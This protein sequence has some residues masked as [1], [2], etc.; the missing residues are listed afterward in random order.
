MRIT[1]RALLAAVFVATFAALAAG[2]GGG[3]G[4]GGDGGGVIDQVITINWGTE[5]PSLDPGLA[6]DTTSSDVL[7]NIMDPLVKLGDNLEPVPNLAESWDV[8]NGGKTVTF[9]LRNDG[10]WTNGDPVTAKDY[11]WSWK[12]TI[13]PD[14]AADY[15]YQFFGIVGA[16]DY[17]SCKSGC[18]AMRDKVGIKATDDHTLRVELTSPQPW[19]VQQVAHTSFLAVNRATVEKFGN[20]WTEPGNIV[21]N[22][23][24]ELATW[25]HNAELDLKKWDAWR[26]A[27]EVKLKRINGRMI[28]EG[29]TAVQAFEAGELDMTAGLPPEELSRLKG[30]DS[31]SQYP[32][33]GTYYYG[34]NVKAIPD[35][36]QRRAM[37]L[38]IDRRTIIDNIAQADQLPPTGFTPKGMPGFDELNPSSPWTPENGDLDKAKEL[39]A[40]VANP[41]KNV[42]LVIND[43]PGHREIAVAIQSMWKELGINT[44]IRQQEWAQFLESLGPPP[45]PSVDAYRLGWIGDYVDAM[46]FLELWTC[47]SGNNNSNYCDPQYDALVAKARQTPD[48]DARYKIYGELEDKLLGENGAVPIAPIYWYTYVQL[49]RPSIKASLNV[50]LLSQTDYTKV[51]EVE[52]S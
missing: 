25:R 42:N 13:S 7:L 34:L 17:N 6:T 39:M 24:F 30:T 43:S 38:A 48:N 50:N 21:T 51:V 40:K 44:T 32:G 8:T 49:E 52:P 15:A 26:N 2:C 23:P 4:A 14:L 18:A 16:E 47:K 36:N 12:R 41:N 27:D 37:S 35:V 3:N 11:E 1:V 46:N 45:D 28:S 19:F 31:Y 10:K 33:L 20:K 29:T 22:G 9:H 5:P